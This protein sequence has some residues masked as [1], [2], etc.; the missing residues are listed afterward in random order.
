MVA[1]LVKFLNPPP[2]LTLARSVSGHD[3][4]VLA[5]CTRQTVIGLG[6]L[7]AVHWTSAAVSGVEHEAIVACLTDHHVVINVRRHAR[8]TVERTACSYRNNNNTIIHEHCCLHQTSD[9]GYPGTCFNNQDDGM[10]TTPQGLLYSVVHSPDGAICIN[11]SDLGSPDFFKLFS[12]EGFV[13]NKQ[14]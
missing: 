8:T 11:F 12:A 6:A 4:P 13:A 7:E 2:R 5:L 1:L 9:N 10:T 3:S 14:Q